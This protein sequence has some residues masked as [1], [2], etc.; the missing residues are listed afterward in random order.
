MNDPN[1][2]VEEYTKLAPHYDRKWWFYIEAST[3]RTI[4]RL[5]QGISGR[6]LDVGCGTGVLLEKLAQTRPELELFAIDPVPAMIE[7]SKRKLN[8]R[9]V[10]QIGA[11]EAIPFTDGF[12]DVVVS[13]NVFHFIREPK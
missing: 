6:L 3:S 7:Q 11:A 2:L 1:P 8:G 13:S 10:L 9:A 5:R 12:F 4:A